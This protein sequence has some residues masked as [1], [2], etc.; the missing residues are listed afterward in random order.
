M[1]AS[2]ARNYN[3]GFNTMTERSH[4]IQDNEEHVYLGFGV[5]YN[6][7]FVKSTDWGTCFVCFDL[8]KDLALKAKH[9]GVGQC[10]EQRDYFGVVEAESSS[11][12][13]FLDWEDHAWDPWGFNI[14]PQG[15]NSWELY[16]YATDS[17]SG[18]YGYKEIDFYS[19]DLKNSNRSRSDTGLT[20]NSN[21][22][23]QCFFGILGSEP[24]LLSTI[25]MASWETDRPFHIDFSHLSNSNLIKSFTGLVMAALALIL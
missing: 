5:N 25:D 14:N 3:T 16:S 23:L 20:W 2:D 10:G 8:N 7:S 1:W 15:M 24:S 11:A 18:N 12:F 4:L 19:F 6:Y 13:H 21:T 22:T 17:G 9:R